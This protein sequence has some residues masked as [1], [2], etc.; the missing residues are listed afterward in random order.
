MHI[1]RVF[2][3]D[4]IAASTFLSEYYLRFRGVDQ[5]AVVV[6]FYDLD[7][8]LTGAPRIDVAVNCHSFSECTLASIQ[9]WLDILDKLGIRYL[10]IVPSEGLYSEG[11]LLTTE[12]G[13][14]HHDYIPTLKSKGWKCIASHPKFLDPL[15]QRHGVTPTHHYLFERSV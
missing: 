14:T 10:M 15:V 13:N 1:E 4:P 8:A 12:R 7:E 11:V 9:S 5:R 6:P 3:I 2:C